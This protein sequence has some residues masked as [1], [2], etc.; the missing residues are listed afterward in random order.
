MEGNRA[1][2]G[3][4]LT[5]IGGIVGIITG[6]VISVIGWGIVAIFDLPAPGALFGV[7]S[8]VLGVIALIGGIYALKKKS[9]IFALIGAILAIPATAI[10][11]PA[12]I[13]GILG[14]IFIAMGKKEFA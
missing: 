14:L 7:P 6:I 9:W 4:I 1:K 12:V 3:G 13:L 8:I 10:L 2:W 11:G 5:L